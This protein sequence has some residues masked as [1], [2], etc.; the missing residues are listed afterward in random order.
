M[1]YGSDTRPLLVDAGLKFKRAEMQM[2]RWMCGISLKDRRT[3]EELRRLVGVDP[4]TTFI[5]SDRLRWYGHVMRKGDEDWVKKAPNVTAYKRWS[6]HS[7]LKLLCKLC[8]TSPPPAMG[9]RF[10]VFGHAGHADQ[11][12]GWRCCS[13]KRVMSRPI[14][15]RQL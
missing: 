11:L 4:I 9:A 3:N 14:Q 2:I 12:D 8:R 6:C 7:R 5:R 13:Q 15:V 10:A 1:T